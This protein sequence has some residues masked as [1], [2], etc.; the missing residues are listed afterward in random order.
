MYET[1]L[2]IENRLDCSKIYPALVIVHLQAG[3]IKKA[4]MRPCPP[5]ITKILPLPP[6]PA[7]M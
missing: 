3:S 2:I 5:W 7:E 4:D 6:D 1:K